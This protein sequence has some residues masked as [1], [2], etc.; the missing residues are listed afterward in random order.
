MS[1]SVTSKV[2]P[3]A[4]ATTHRIPPL[5][6]QRGV[7]IFLSLIVLVALMLGGIALFRSVDSGILIAGNVALQ[8]NATRSGDAGVENA[9]AWLTANAGGTLYYDLPA[10]GYIAAGLTNSKLG[11]QTWADYWTAITA[12]TTPVAFGEDASGN[13][14]AYII[15][16]M[17]DVQGK[18]YSTG[19]NCVE[20]PA[21]SGTGSGK[22]AGAIA[23]KRST[24]VYYRI[25]VRTVGPKNA[26]S[27]IQTTVLM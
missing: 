4:P 13:A 14:V 25:I 5:S 6:R 8:K 19:V 3:R 24:S 1:V 7:V 27:F 18:E 20:P 16:R 23:L 10:N 26:V 11:N 9:I 12:S 15:Q 2:G 22:G 17:C 21:S